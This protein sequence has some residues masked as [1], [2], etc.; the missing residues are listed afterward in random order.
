[1]SAACRRLESCFGGVGRGSDWCGV[2]EG[3]VG[4]VVVISLSSKG[5][6]GDPSVVLQSSVL[7][8]GVW[9]GGVGGVKGGWFGSGGEECGSV[10]GSIVIVGGVNIAAIHLSMSAMFLRA[11]WRNTSKSKCA[12]WGVVGGRKAG[13][14]CSGEGC[15]SAVVIVSCIC[16]R[17]KR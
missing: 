9:C 17:G 7:L 3:G 13:C 8:A 6:G 2:W 12:H 16:A 10:V 5:Y 1:V 4:S 11:C 14:F 15:C